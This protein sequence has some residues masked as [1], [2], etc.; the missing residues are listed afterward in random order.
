MLQTA[1]WVN[2]LAGS[3]KESFPQ[4]TQARLGA[5]TRWLLAL[6]DLPS[7]GVPNLGP[8][9]G[10]NIL[11]L[12]VCT[13]GD[14]RPVLQSAAGAFLCEQPFAAGPWDEM[15]LWLAKDLPAISK[16]RSSTSP[17]P[18]PA[19]D[20]HVL[21]SP[22]GASWAYLRLARFTGRPGHADQLHL[23][24]WWR[25]FNV[26]Q[27]A[28]TF[29]YN[30]R[31]PWDN[32]LARG[33]V[34]NT[35]VIDGQDQ[36]RRAGRFLY[37]DRAQVEVLKQDGWEAGALWFVAARHNGYHNQ[38][39]WHQREVTAG[40]K[41]NWEI[42]DLIYPMS[43]IGSAKVHTASLHWLL[44]DWPWEVQP[45]TEST[46]F[47]ITL[48]SPFGPV[49]LMLETES[50]DGHA[51]SPSLLISKAGERAWGEGEVSPVWG[52]SSP[53]YGVKTPALS[54]RC[55]L[56]GSVPL[57]FTSKF[58]FPLDLQPEGQ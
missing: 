33:E 51:V 50:S 53:T 19:H 34:H 39:L 17:Q 14:Y 42:K 18:D 57:G 22:D 11:P 35:L 56:T 15:A 30:A 10:A 28:G 2:F 46:S 1:L 31:P 23:D 45:A 8:N 43:P 54:L 13:Q 9:D 41:G 20:P 27:D 40:F 47:I 58:A 21:R 25:G 4:D 12:T 52:F 49:R 55:T 36:M 24:L 3:Q 5:A 48:S 26:A 16:S 6:L 7:G 38:G 32:A 37:V 29:S 44:P